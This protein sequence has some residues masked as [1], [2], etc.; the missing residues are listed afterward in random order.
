MTHRGQRGL[1]YV[2][3]NA[4]KGKR[5]KSTRTLLYLPG[6]WAAVVAVLALA[7]GSACGVT[8]EQMYA[9][10][11]KAAEHFEAEHILLPSDSQETRWVGAVGTRI[12]ESWP[13]RRW[14]THRFLV[15]DSP[16]ASAWS[17]PTSPVHHNVYVT[18]GLLDFIRERAGERCDDW[19]AGV[20]GHEIAHLLRDHHVLRHRAANALGMEVPKELAE[21]PARVLGEW[22]QEDEVEAD[23]Y[24]AF[25]ALHAGYEF[26]GLMEFLGHYARKYG[27]DHHRFLSGHSAGEDRVHPPLSTRIARLQQE[28]GET[29]EAEQLF[30]H[31]LDLVRVGAWDAASRCFAQVRNR[32]RLSPTVVHNEAFARLRLYESSLAGGPPIEQC[33]STSY[34]VVLRL[35][36][37]ETSDQ[38]A[39]LAEAKSGFLKACDLDRERRFVA[40]RLGLA[41]VY[42]YEGDDAKAEACLQELQVGT[43]ESAYLNLTG[44]LAEH[45]GDLAAAW[46]AYCKALSLPVHANATEAATGLGCLSQP[47]LPALYNLARL[48]ECQRQQAEAARLYAHYL[49]FEGNRSS[50]GMRA[51]EGLVRCGGTLPGAEDPEVV[52]S[53]HGINLKSSGELVVKAALG[54][55][56]RVETF[57]AGEAKPVVYRYP[58]QGVSVVLTAGPAG[59]AVATCIHLEEPNQDRV[60]GVRVGD[61]AALLEA[62]L[63]RPREVIG[64]PDG[65]A[66]WDYTRWGVAF[67][68]VDGRVGECLIGGRR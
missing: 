42:L 14:I 55:P 17:F 10:W 11:G 20:I 22:Q 35:K 59:D 5:M 47:H 66:W 58:S 6:V 3:R 65:A 56:E 64:G 13:D 43:D 8:D 25:Y 28:R 57:G 63:G 33:A 54:E 39:L 7:G 36:G 23:S 52:D 31:G 45:R 15:V 26:S 37:P 21:W 16:I 24:G 18:T 51:R 61:G 53:Y 46:R 32:F 41:C 62:R 60:G 19:L 27:D 38:Q 12:V 67:R 68:V 1:R 30:E 40:P 2:L 50:F 29:E 34:I 48:A 9:L 49:M 44:V 4:G